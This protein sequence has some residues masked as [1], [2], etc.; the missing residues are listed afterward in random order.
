MSALKD[1]SRVAAGRKAARTAKKRYGGGYHRNIGAK[2]GRSTAHA[3]AAERS[4]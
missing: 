1:P 2:G 3:A 4:P